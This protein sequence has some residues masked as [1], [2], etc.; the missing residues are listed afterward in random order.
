[1]S[2]NCY[3][4]QPHTATAGKVSQERRRWRLSYVTLIRFPT[5][6]TIKTQIIENVN[7]I[8]E[9]LRV[10]LSS[11]RARVFSPLDNGSGIILGK[12]SH[13]SSSHC[14]GE[15]RQGCHCHCHLSS[16]LSPS[17][18]PILHQ[19][20]PFLCHYS[21]TVTLLLSLSV[22]V[23]LF[24]NMPQDGCVRALPFDPWAGPLFFFLLLLCCCCLL[25]FAARFASI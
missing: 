23:S 21:L 25:C 9:A 4:R 6:R 10:A 8:V 11:Y 3:K 7:V 13:T 2:S 14:L 12:M 5:S 16:A 20:C 1:M 24:C 18:S 17:F 15:A 19:H 22:S